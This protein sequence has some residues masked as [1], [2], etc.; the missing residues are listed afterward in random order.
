MYDNAEYLN[1]SYPSNLTSEEQ[2]DFVTDTATVLLL[3]TNI[4]VFQW[5]CLFFLP[6]KCVLI[7]IVSTFFMFLSVRPSVADR[8]GHRGGPGSLLTGR[9]RRN[10]AEQHQCR[11]PNRKTAWFHLGLGVELP[12]LQTLTWYRPPPILIFLSPCLFFF[13][14]LHIAFVICSSFLR[15]LS[16]NDLKWPCGSFACCFVS[17]RWPECSTVSSFAQI[18]AGSSN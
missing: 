6:L 13:S 2:M 18:T 10:S 9:R 14:S 7:N 5:V 4:Y 11:P 3:L 1:V 17:L 15:C 16:G 12:L 8:R